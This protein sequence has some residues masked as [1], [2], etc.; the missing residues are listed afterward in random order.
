MRKA[1]QVNAIR[2]LA[3]LCLLC[4]DIAAAAPSWMN[5]SVTPNFALSMPAVYPPRP[6]NALCPSVMV[7]A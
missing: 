7:P 4:T 2:L 6:K 3:L 1:M 5:G